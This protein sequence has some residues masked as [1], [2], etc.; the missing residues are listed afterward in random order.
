MNCAHRSI[1]SKNVHVDTEGKV[2]I[3]DLSSC[4]F[5]TVEEPALTSVEANEAH[6]APEAVKQNSQHGLA[7][8]VWALGILAYEICAGSPQPRK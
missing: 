8:D 1:R 5:L 3:S 2:K 7:V 6:T 4:T